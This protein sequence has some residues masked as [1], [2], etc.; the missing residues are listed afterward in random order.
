[1]PAP[2]LVAIHQPNFFPW[3]GYFNKI[4][5]A[6]VFVVLDDVQFPKTGGTWCNRVKVLVRGKPAWVTMP[7][8]RSHHGVRLIREVTSVPT[9]WRHDVLS[10]LENAY[11]RAAHFS[12]I[13]PSLSELIQAPMARIAEYNLAAVLALVERLRFDTRKLVLSSTLGAS[14]TATERLAA[15]VK[16]VDGTAYL[17]GGGS[18]G[19]QDDAVFAAAGIDVVY[20]SF[21]HPVYPQTGET[22]FAPGLSIIDALMN[23][24]S[25]ATRALVLESRPPLTAGAQ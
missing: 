10:T 3:L 20:Q 18:S 5:F 15:L 7:V 11:A 12:E 25:E 19:Y 6:D 21:R 13:F 17:A 8:D 1:M 9:R 24:G 23:C 4:A 14:G 2:R 22:V 16:A